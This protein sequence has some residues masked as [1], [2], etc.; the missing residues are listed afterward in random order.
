M[1][2]GE[3]VPLNGDVHGPTLNR[4]AR[5]RD[6]ARAGEILLSAST[7]DRG[8]LLN[9][10]ESN[11]Q[12]VGVI[13]N[14][15]PRLVGVDSAPIRRQAIVL[16]SRDEVTLYDMSTR[17]AVA[18]LAKA[19]TS[20]RVP[21]FSPDGDVVAVSSYSTECLGSADCA[22]AA[23]EVFDARDLSP[24]GVR[25]DGFPYRAA[26]VA[27]SP[28]GSSLAAI[29]PL[30]WANSGGNIAV[31]RVDAPGEPARRLSLR[32]VGEDRFLTPFSPESGWIRFSPDGTRLY[33]SGAGPTIALD[34]ATGEEVAR[35]DGLGALALSPD[36]R[37]IAINMTQ[38]R[39]ELFDTASGARRAQLTGHDAAVIAAVFSADGTMIASVSNDETVIVWD[40]STGERRQQFHGHAGSVLGVD[41][42]ADGSELFTSGADGSVIIWDLD[43]T[44]GLT[45]GLAPPRDPRA[46]RAGQLQP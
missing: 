20:Y 26:D 17:Q 8:N 6:L 14:G 4:A 42:S 39:I 3:L 27:F 5:V 9:T 1:A 7:A 23:V 30:P 10:I 45:R 35:F 38:D 43:R 31:W 33:A 13:R 11:P 34:V 37:T 21:D 25:Y 44:R 2:T 22:D 24:R 29:G 40:V 18:S 16:D 12:A 32:D 15:Q 19:G 41:F 36:G 46:W 28:D